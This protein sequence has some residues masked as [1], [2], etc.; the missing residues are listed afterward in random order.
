MKIAV[1]GLG[2]SIKLYTP[3]YNLTIGVN[4]IWRVVKTDVVVCL[5]NPFVFNPDRLKTINECKPRAFYSQMVIWDTRPDFVKIDFLPGYPDNIVQFETTKLHKSLCSP[6]VACEIAYKFYFADEIH[7]FGVDLTNHPHLS[8]ELCAK[9][10][11]HFRNLKT[12]LSQ[13][14]CELIIHGEGILK[15]L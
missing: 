2:E 15:D 7:I 3:E 4:D 5:D 11:T 6:F 13:K 9:I 8:G 10:V 12:A 1:C 14:G